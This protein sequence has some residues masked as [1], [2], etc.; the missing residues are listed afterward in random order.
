[1]YVEVNK[2]IS[3]NDKYS[4]L[5]GKWWFIRPYFKDFHIAWFPPYKS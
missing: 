3:Y 1:M 2:T 5:K 4:V